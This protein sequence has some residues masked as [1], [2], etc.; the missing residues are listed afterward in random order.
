MSGF[1]FNLS[2]TGSDADKHE[3]DFYDV[4]K[5][6]IGFQRSLALT[7]HLVL[8]DEVITQSPSLNGARIIAL[9]PEE[10]SWTFA[11]LIAFGASA[12]Y[13]LGTA[14]KDTPL[15]NIMHSAYDYVISETL[16]FHIDYDKSLGQQYNALKASKQNELPILE[17]SRFDSVVEK[18]EVAV[19][20]MHRP[21]VISETAEE[22]KITSSF[23]GK[24]RQMRNAMNA[25]TYEYV[26]TTIEG[27]RPVEFTGR[28]S[29]YNINTFKGRIFIARENRPIPFELGDT[30]HGRRDISAII[31]SMRMNARS[32]MPGR[33]EVTVKAFRRESRSGRLKGLFIVEVLE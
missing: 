28:V 3:I 9:P 30:A 13:K 15:G 23:G 29:S 5:A 7:T 26:H 18:C 22:A 8:N 32:R 2:Y 17:Q 19:K 10:G 12:I 1:E 16:G 11:A 14:P 33:G 4:G 25:K 31:D 21:I 20:D 24:P 27:E 6:L